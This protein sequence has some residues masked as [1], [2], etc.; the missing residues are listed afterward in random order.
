MTLYPGK[1]FLIK[2]AETFRSTRLSYCAHAPCS[3]SVFFSRSNCM[4]PASSTLSSGVTIRITQLP[5]MGTKSSGY[6]RRR[7][8]WSSN[9]AP[10]EI[11]LLRL[12]L[13]S[14]RRNL[15]GIL[16]AAKKAIPRTLSSLVIFLNRVSNFFKTLL[17][18]RSRSF[19]Q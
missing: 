16:F 8:S 1:S 6:H 11:Y 19:S 2:R 4:N 17:E 3:S 18:E 5:G 13:L 7:C 10:Q 14:R 9:R 15:S 12:S